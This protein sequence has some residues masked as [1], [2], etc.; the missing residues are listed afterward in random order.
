MLLFINR[1][2]NHLLRWYRKRVFLLQI[3]IQKSDVRLSGRVNLLSGIKSKI[4]LGGGVLYMM[5]Q[6]SGV[7]QLH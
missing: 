5:E 6:H 3:G 4:F 1:C 7:A 2:F